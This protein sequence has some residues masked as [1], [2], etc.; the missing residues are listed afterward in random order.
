MKTVNKIFGHYFAPLPVFKKPVIMKMHIIT[1]MK[2]IGEP[3]RRDLPVFGDAGPG[4]KA[5]IN[6]YE[7]IINLVDHPDT[8][9]IARKRRIERGKAFIEVDIEYCFFGSGRVWVAGDE[10]RTK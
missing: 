4:F 10:E 2:C 7:P 1:E 9:L 3:I 5:V 6:L 8:E